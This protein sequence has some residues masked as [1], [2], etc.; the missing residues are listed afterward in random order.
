[1]EGKVGCHKLVDLFRGG[2]GIRE[3]AAGK[4]SKRWRVGVRGEPNNDVVA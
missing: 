1:M 4:G 3:D 2:F